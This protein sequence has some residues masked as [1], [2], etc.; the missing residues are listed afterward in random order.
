M[1]QNRILWTDDIKIISLY[2]KKLRELL[3]K[4]QSLESITDWVQI[5][6][7]MDLWKLVEETRPLLENPAKIWEESSIENKR[8]L[9]KVLFNDNL[10]YWKIS[11][12]WTSEI[13]LIYRDLS[14][15]W[16][17]NSHLVEIA[18]NLLHPLEQE[19]T[20]KQFLIATLY[21]SIFVGDNQVKINA[22]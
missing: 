6:Q 10:T 9:V 16:S 20:Q 15:F 22:L 3:D 19:L 2:E 5:K 7:H 14:L 8:L 13:P 1:M 18:F 17:T 21:N 11:G 4:K 12:I